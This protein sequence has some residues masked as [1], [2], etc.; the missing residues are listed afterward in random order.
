M[1]PVSEDPEV[2]NNESSVPGR[3]FTGSYA[4]KD[5]AWSKINLKLLEKKGSGQVKKHILQNVWGRARA[6]TTT[7][8]M[9][10]SGS[11]SKFSTLSLLLL[12]TKLFISNLK[13][14]DQKCCYLTPISVRIQK[15]TSLFQILAGRLPS[16][17]S[18]QQEGDIYFGGVKVD[19]RDREQRKLFAYVAQEDSL[20]ESST[21][22]EALTF[23][24]KLRLPKATTDGEIDELVHKK[25]TDLGMESAADT[26]I[27]GSFR[28]GISGGERRRVSI[29]LELVASP[30]V[31]M[32]DEPTSG[33]DSYATTQVIKLLNDVA[34][35]GNTVLFTIHQPS[36]KIFCSFDRLI[37]LK[38]GQVMHQGAVFSLQEEFKNAGYPI[39]TNYN[40][41]DW[42]L[43][44]AES[45]DISELKNSFFAREPEDNIAIAKEGEELVIPDRDHVS[46]WREYMLLEER[47]FREIKRNPG[48]TIINVSITG[49]L[50][51]IFG[52]LFWDIG[53]ADRSAMIVRQ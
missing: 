40:P 37:L 3:S 33:L 13:S 6:G 16:Q 51:L 11:G 46:M 26:I 35:A 30:S 8:I 22:R 38:T 15:E 29:G 5:L 23:S 41:A 39:P 25:L 44:V 4:G 34:K 21:P 9:G 45:N 28:K 50:A 7:A 42:V 49:V 27:G 10:A 48:L 2:G 24:A 52:V 32:L 14:H 43:D 17:S 19:P 47:E 36:S 31:I 53:R 18:L 12:P 20:H 1:I